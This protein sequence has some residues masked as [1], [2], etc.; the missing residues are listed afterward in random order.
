MKQSTAKKW[1]E[2]STSFCADLWTSASLLP[3][4]QPCMGGEWDLGCATQGCWLIK[5][6]EMSCRCDLFWSPVKSLWCL[7]GSLFIFFKAAVEVHLR[8]N[9]Y[10]RRTWFSKCLRSI[11][12]HFSLVVLFS[13][14][15]SSKE[16]GAS[17]QLFLPV[18]ESFSIEKAYFQVYK[19]RI[20]F[21]KTVS[22]IDN[23]RKKTCDFTGGRKC[24]V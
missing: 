3:P 11:H 17:A 20:S 6:T 16:K 8:I 14:E 19:Q 21:P 22:Q 12:L 18:K 13:Q 24:C 7:L 23:K 2:R 5:W 9:T 15:M 1:V 10:F 4:L